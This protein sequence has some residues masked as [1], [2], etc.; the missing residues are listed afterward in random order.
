VIDIETDFKIVYRGNNCTETYLLEFP[1]EVYLDVYLKG[2][3]V[4][5]TF[6]DYDDK[7]SREIGGTNAKVCGNKR[8]EIKL[9]GRLADADFIRFDE[10]RLKLMVSA[11]K[12]VKVGTYL[13]EILILVSMV[14]VPNVHNST[15][16]IL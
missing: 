13:S 2:E 7:V 11:D 6:D 12:L 8:F 1:N 15:N 16:V 10:S 9:Q 5:L 3:D 4:E 14:D